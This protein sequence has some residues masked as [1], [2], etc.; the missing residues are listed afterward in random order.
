M[1][2]T[3]VCP[4]AAMALWGLVNH[5]NDIPDSLITVTESVSPRSTWYNILDFLLVFLLL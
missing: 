3:D 4:T 2:Q 1:W 5:Y